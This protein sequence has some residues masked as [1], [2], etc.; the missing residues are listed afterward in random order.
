[1][2]CY[3]RE[4]EFICSPLPAMTSDS[5]VKLSSRV[6]PMAVMQMWSDKKIALEKEHDD[7]R[8]TFN[9]LPWYA[10]RARHMIVQKLLDN[11]H[12]Y[13]EMCMRI[14]FWRGFQQAQ[15]QVKKLNQDS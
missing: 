4:N 5:P 6:P 10:I 13:V 1:M 7:L 15:E 3:H 11:R 2:V 12:S 8:D 9:S 14:S